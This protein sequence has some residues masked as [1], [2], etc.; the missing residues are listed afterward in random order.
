[1]FESLV[2]ARTLTSECPAPGRVLTEATVFG[3]DVRAELQLSYLECA[4]SSPT[5]RSVGLRQIPGESPEPGWPENA[6]T[7]CTQRRPDGSEYFRIETHP[8]AGYLIWG[9]GRGSYL[10]SPD[11]GRLCC[12]SGGA[13]AQMWERFLIGQVLPFTALVWGL[14]V[15][16]AS[17][18]VLD[19]GAVAFAGPSGSGKTSV[20]LEC[21]RSGAGFLA[22]DVLALEPRAYGL[23]AQPG[24]PVAGVD[25][26]EARRLRD[27]GR[28]IA[29]EVLGADQR[30]QVLRMD[31][32]TC[33]VPLAALF[34]LD[35][36]PEGT[37][38]PS[39]QPAADARMLLASTFNFVLDTPQ[40]TR[41][42]LDVCALAAQSRVERIVISPS[43]DAG[44]LAQAVMSRL[45]GAA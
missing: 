19:G 15:F 25:H 12:A 38:G 23:M 5:G 7:I 6:R 32:A 11:G 41:G 9:E 22:D 31:G 45:G 8:L 29:N 40:R 33:P 28:P 21:C 10:L 20:A 27:A 26:G 34:F 42:L 18:V 24:T 2:S 16:H 13:P 43:T 36:R 30:E 17:A 14:E 37:D 35:R 44:E 1:M 39:F 3:L 4:P